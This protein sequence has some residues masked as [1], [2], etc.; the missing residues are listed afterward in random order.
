MRLRAILA[1]GIAALLLDGQRGRKEFWLAGIQR[2]WLPP[3]PGEIGL[4]VDSSRRGAGWR[5]VALRVRGYPQAIFAQR[6]QLRGVA[7]PKVERRDLRCLNGD[8]L[9]FS[10]RETGSGRRNI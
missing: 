3:H 2:A 5:R 8:A 6:I 9:L 4:A 7:Q 10:R 1:V